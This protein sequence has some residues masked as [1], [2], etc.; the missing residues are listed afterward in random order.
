MNENQFLPFQPSACMLGKH[1]T[2]WQNSPRNGITT[3]ACIQV[4]TESVCVC[5]HVRV[6]I[7]YK[8]HIYIYLLTLKNREGGIGEHV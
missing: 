8:V 4:Y 1:N 3:V 5:A 6:C 2:N 7:A